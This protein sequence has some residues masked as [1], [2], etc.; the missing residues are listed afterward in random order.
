MSQFW[1]VKGALKPPFLSRSPLTTLVLNSTCLAKSAYYLGWRQE[2][3][4]CTISHWL[5]GMRLFFPRLFQHFGLDLYRS[6]CCAKVTHSSQRWLDF[7]MTLKC[8]WP[9][10]WHFLCLKLVPSLW[11][12]KA[13]VNLSAEELMKKM[14]WWSQPGLVF[15]FLS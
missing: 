10:T 11:L 9:G 13:D 15:W 5:A 12:Y 6:N 3:S 4:S 7:S 8:I 1:R 14:C 2:T